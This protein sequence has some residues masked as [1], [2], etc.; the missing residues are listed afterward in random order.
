MSSGLVQFLKAFIQYIPF[1]YT[2][3]N[4]T[5]ITFDT[6]DDGGESSAVVITNEGS[7]NLPEDTGN[8]FRDLC[9][10]NF[11]VFEFVQR[12]KTDH[13]HFP[14]KLRLPKAPFIETVI[15]S[16]T[17]K[18]AANS[19]LVYK[20]SGFV[21]LSNLYKNSLGYWEIASYQKIERDNLRFDRVINLTN[22]TF[23]INKYDY[24]HLLW[25][26]MEINPLETHC[27]PPEEL[28][29]VLDGNHRTWSIQVFGSCITDNIF[30]FIK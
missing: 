9:L 19:A 20:S 12:V 25:S 30:P 23:R 24:N 1:R 21:C 26:C 18:E 11:H 22:N 29:F 10:S 28:V 3:F 17:F 16:K 14:G 8:F 15:E 4:L 27:D 7:Y 13:I 6:V 2:S 5:T